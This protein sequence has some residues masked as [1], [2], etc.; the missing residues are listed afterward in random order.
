MFKNRVQEIRD[1]EET[2]NQYADNERTKTLN[3]GR[4]ASVIAIPCI[5]IFIM[6]DIYILGFQE[7]LPWRIAAIIPFVLFILFS[8]TI[9]K[10]IPALIIPV[11]AMSLAG[12]II[13][14]CGI[15]ALLVTGS[16]CTGSNLQPA[17][18]GLMVD[19][20]AVSIFASG[21]RKFIPLIIPGPL[22]VLI[23]L[24]IFQ[25]DI[26]S[27]NLSTLSNPLLAALIVSVYSVYQEKLNF[28]EFG[29]RKR[30][31]KNER[32]IAIQHNSMATML[33]S[34]DESAFLMMPDGTIVYANKTMGERIHV[35]HELLA[36]MNAYDVTPPEVSES[37][38]VKAALCIKTKEPVVFVDERNGRSIH[39]TIHPVLDENND[40]IYLAI[41]GF[42]ITGRI[43]SEN[44]IRR[45]LDEKKLLLKE[46]HH[47]VKNNMMSISGLLTLK[48]ESG[49]NAESAAILKEM[50]VR[51]MT[52]MR[53][54]DRLYRSEEYSRIHLREYLDDLLNEISSTFLSGD[55]IKIEHDIEDLYIRQSSVFAIGIIVNEL[56][57]NSLKYAFPGGRKGFISITLRTKGDSEIKIV[58]HDNGIGLPHTNEVTL[59][60]GFGLDLVKIMVEQSGGSIAAS[61]ENGTTF[62]VIMPYKLP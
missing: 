10:K 37:R 52:M 2:R 34:I 59:N 8:F 44:E 58:I 39:N 7:F 20:F 47:R 42:D 11:H 13:M 50:S 31:E 53:I 40:V 6:Q 62:T 15:I 32:I 28:S 19:I 12:I 48:S 24:I 55:S 29:S 30:A 43:R 3:T 23:V 38:R 60:A 9:F 1:T 5:I 61:G 45:L 33:N 26:P 49:V 56:V 18:T 14:M 51:V 41:F 25:C 17:A 36:G 57:T 27:Q 4:L 21:A 22:A 46:V 54:Y 16:R 35:S